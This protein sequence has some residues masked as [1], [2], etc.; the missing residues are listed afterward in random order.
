MQGHVDGVGAVVAVREDGFA[1]VVTIA[2][3]NPAVLRYVVHK[4][5]ISIS[6][7]R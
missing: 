7:S 2:P 3:D 4:G 1:R 6:G 5:S